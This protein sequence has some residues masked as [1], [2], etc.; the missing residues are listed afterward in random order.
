[1]GGYVLKIY[2]GEYLIP[3]DNDEQAEI[4]AKKVLDS[5]GELRES[6]VLCHTRVVT[7]FPHKLLKRELEDPKDFLLCD[8]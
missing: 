6:A 3:A 1:M 5:I 8:D 7:K 4:E 2:S